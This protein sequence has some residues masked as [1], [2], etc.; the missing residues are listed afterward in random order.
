MEGKQTVPTEPMIAPVYYK[1]VPTPYPNTMA[2]PQ[3]NANQVY[4]PPPTYNVAA[5]PQPQ[6]G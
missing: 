2:Y 4:L 1:P 6:T 5:N 3:G